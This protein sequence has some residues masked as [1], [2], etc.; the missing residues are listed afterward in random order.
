MLICGSVGLASDIGVW[1]RT[2]RAMQ[3]AADAAAVAA[4][5]DSSSTAWSDTGKAVAARYGFV[6]RVDGIRVQIA[7]DQTCPT[8]GL[9]CFKA[10]IDDDAAP[11]FF[12]K[13]LGIAAPP[14]STSA[15]ASSSLRQYCVLALATSGANPAVQTNGAPFRRS[16]PL[17]YHVEYRH[18]L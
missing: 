2:A 9:N 1:Y 7:R 18:D 6:D 14:L 12:S 8:G 16:Q 5:R 10:T 4:A 15:T 3:N 17:Q 13:V 11:Q